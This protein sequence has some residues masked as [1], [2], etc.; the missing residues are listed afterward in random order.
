MMQAHALN[1]TYVKPN[2]KLK[3]FSTDTAQTSWQPI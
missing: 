1:N 3:T 2:D